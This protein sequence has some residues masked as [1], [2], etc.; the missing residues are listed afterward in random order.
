MGLIGMAVPEKY[1][2]NFDV[3]SESYALLIHALKE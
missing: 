1:N 2:E 3:S